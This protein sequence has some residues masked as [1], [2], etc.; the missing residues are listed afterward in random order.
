MAAAGITVTI[1]GDASGLV[2][3]AAEAS[4]ALNE[5]SSLGS[6]L[7]S[8]ALSITIEATD[9]A[10][11]AIE[12]ASAALAAM[13]ADHN[14]VLNAQDNVTMQAMT[15]AAAVNAVPLSHNTDLNAVD[16]ASATAASVAAAIESIPSSKTVTINIVTNGS[17]PKIAKGT[18]DFEGG[19][20][21]VNDQTGIADPRELI[22]HD[23]MAYMYEGRNVIAPIPRHARVYTASQTKAI[24][25]GLGI[26]HFAGGYYPPEFQF[27]IG[28]DIREIVQR[29]YD[30][31]YSTWMYGNDHMFMNGGQVVLALENTDFTGL[32]ETEKESLI[33]EKLDQKKKELEGSFANRWGLNFETEAS[34]YNPT[35][36]AIDRMN[37]SSEL[38]A[39]QEE[40]LEGY[41]DLA[42]QE[43]SYGDVLSHTSTLID[44]RLER[45]NALN[46]AN[47]EMR[48]EMEYLQNSSG[49]EGIQ[50]WTDELGNATEEY[51]AFLNSLS[52]QEEQDKAESYFNDIQ[53]YQQKIIANTEE[54]RDLTNDISSMRLD[55]NS[56]KFELWER[57]F[58]NWTQMHEVY[59]DWEDVGDSLSQS[60]ARAIERQREFFEAG[61]IGW[62]DYHDNVFEYSL[63]MYKAASDEY[64][65]MLAEQSEYINK[66]QEEFSKQEEELRTSWDVED[67]GADLDEV[68][69]LLAIYD[70]SVTDTGRQK[71]K[72]LLEQKKQLEREEKLYQL[73]VRNNAVLEQLRTEYD[74]MEEN[75]KAALSGLRMTGDDIASSNAY[76]SDTAD[77]IRSLAA[78][79]GVQYSAAA[80]STL[81]TLEDIYQLLSSIKNVL[82]IR[83]GNS[84]TYN[85]SRTINVSSG[86]SENSVRAIIN[87]TVLSGLA[88][89]IY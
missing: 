35:D 11:P 20:A 43:K 23:G 54:I 71:Y 62:Q 83:A 65:E 14:T 1:D 32:S 9:N 30:E 2:S 19:L 72:D 67:R 82:G 75:K 12:S 73:Q 69:R 85:D 88:D 56:Q 68:N 5:L 15:A 48:N 86:L 21:M 29:L 42:E 7:G 18:R 55:L 49:Y 59:G 77:D 47:A 8:E 10:T 6:S 13:P 74:V 24:M 27:L 25:S 50:S 41:I 51:Y 80:D 70:N 87:G 3:A 84:Q 89:F 52:T 63:E 81:N 79:I 33:R 37:L 76:I 61:I 16:N 34:Y 46:Q 28:E 4:A 53:K 22:V 78:A 38:I 64:D 66:M 17:V 40:L 39:N 36:A 60:Y 44:T 45:V 57:D 58:E 31:E 26:P